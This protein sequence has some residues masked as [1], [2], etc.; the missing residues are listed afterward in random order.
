MSTAM[1]LFGVGCAALGAAFNAMLARL[2]NRIDMP[3]NWTCPE[4]QL[5]VSASSQKLVAAL[6]TAHL[7]SG[8]PS[9]QGG[10]ANV[11]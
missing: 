5:T 1:V 2:L 7:N 4:C 10:D 3:Y 8:G 9:T 11:Q 6:K